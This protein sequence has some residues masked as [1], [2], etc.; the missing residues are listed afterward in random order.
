MQKEVD[1]MMHE[2]NK[3]ELEM[4]DLKERLRKRE[5]EL[6]DLKVNLNSQISG[7]YE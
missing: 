2:Q 3:R 5:D 6:R 7:V 4:S 1:F